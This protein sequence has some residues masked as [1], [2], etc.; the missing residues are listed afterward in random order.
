MAN[1]NVSGKRFRSTPAVSEGSKQDLTRDQVSIRFGRQTTSSGD[2]ENGP[3]YVNFN[4]I[5]LTD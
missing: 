2:R 4:T 1:D 5:I 3:M